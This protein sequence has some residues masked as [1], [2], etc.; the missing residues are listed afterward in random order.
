M[1][2]FGDGHK[3]AI[4]TQFRGSL[5]LRCVLVVTTRLGVLVRIQAGHPYVVGIRFVILHIEGDK[6]PDIVANQIL[7]KILEH[8]AD[9]TKIG[10]S[11]T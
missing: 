4:L 8:C 5:F 2:F 9:L 3:V 10:V 6:S 11:A 1:Q 7:Q